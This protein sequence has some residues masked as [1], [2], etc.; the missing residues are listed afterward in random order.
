MTLDWERIENFVGFGNQKPRV[1]FL[2]MEEGLARDAD[3]LADLRLRSR[4]DSYMDLAEAQTQLGG[5]AKYFGTFPKTQRTW[6]P[7]CHLM[8]RR[9]G[10]L[11]PT[12]TQRLR[13]QA[14]ALGRKNS[15]SL[16]VELL[17]YPHPDS[18]RW[19]YDKF[20]RFKT[21]AAYETAIL[22]QRMRLL[23]DIITEHPP[24]IIVAYGKG[25]WGLYKQLIN[26]ASWTADAP[27]EFTDAGGT[28]VV[29]VPHLA[30]KHFG[31]D[32]QLDAF[33]DIAL[34]T[35]P[36]ATTEQRVT[37]ISDHKNQSPQRTDAVAAARREAN[38][39]FRRG[40]AALAAAYRQSNPTLTAQ[41]I[42]LAVTPRAGQGNP[43]GVRDL[44]RGLGWV[45]PRFATEVFRELQ[46][47]ESDLLGRAYGD[48][49]SFV[50]GR[51]REA[52]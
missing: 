12:L 44:E 18:G 52:D 22:P 51:V 45:N 20:E 31:T 40:F 7:M 32:K 15:E 46:M 4:Y 43:T 17:P 19:L 21:R 3:L 27:F 6:R 5:P 38:R 25:N 37:T 1:L 24:E 8:L 47:P 41:A 2:G 34:A 10:V 29:L 35:Q 33:A 13:Y 39:H 48:L 14:D 23:R 36:D 30:K 16:L 28:R 42:A 9:A 49:K 50:K 11:H 26:I